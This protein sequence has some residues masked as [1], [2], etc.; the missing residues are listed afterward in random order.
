MTSYKKFLKTDTI[1]KAGNGM[2]IQK[3]QCIER[4]NKNGL[5]ISTLNSK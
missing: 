3:G 1:G 5:I 4:N 2:L